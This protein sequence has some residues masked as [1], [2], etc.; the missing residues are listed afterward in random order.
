MEKI[1]VRFDG[2]KFDI[3]PEALEPLLLLE[4][5]YGSLKNIPETIEGELKTFYCM[6]KG[7]NDNFNVSFDRFVK[8]LP[9]QSG[10]IEDMRAILLK[11]KITKAKTAKYLRVIALI[12]L[13]VTIIAGWT[14]AGVMLKLFTNLFIS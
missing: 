11:K 10:F 13:I 5:E 8:L 12:I 4:K 3:I 6:L 14:L 9:F 2:Q 7:S 1:T